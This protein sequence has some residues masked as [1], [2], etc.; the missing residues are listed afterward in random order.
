M[1]TN[2][3]AV[4]LAAT[5]DGSRLSGEPNFREMVAK[6]HGAKVIVTLDDGQKFDLVVSEGKAKSK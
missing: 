4:F 3:L 2:E 6:A 5:L 1:T